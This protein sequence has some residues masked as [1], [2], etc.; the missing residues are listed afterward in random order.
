MI[1]SL[2]HSETSP[3]PTSH[4]SPQLLVLTWEGSSLPLPSQPRITNSG[5]AL[6]MDQELCDVLISPNLNLLPRQEQSYPRFIP[7]HGNTEA[8][9]EVSGVTL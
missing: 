4:L 5:Y 1:P 8:R 2:A 3:P 6:M 9:W 7:P